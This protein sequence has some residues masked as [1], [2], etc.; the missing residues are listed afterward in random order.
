MG[1]AHNF[2]DWVSMHDEVGAFYMFCLASEM[3]QKTN[4]ALLGDSSDDAALGQS[5]LFEPSSPAEVSEHL[6]DLGISLPTPEA[7]HDVP[8]KKIA[9]FAKRRAG[10]RLRFREEVE[11]GYF[12][13]EQWLATSFHAPLFSIQVSVQNTVRARCSPLCMSS[14]ARV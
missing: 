2:G 14:Y 9:D 11:D 6:L 7:L 4:A 3:G 12:V 13:C 1:I 10:E 5:L 8:I